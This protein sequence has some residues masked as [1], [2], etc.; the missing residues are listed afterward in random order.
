MDSHTW[1]CS[2]AHN[3]G[4]VVS[5]GD[6][7]AVSGVLLLGKYTLHAPH[8][9]TRTLKTLLPLYM[10]TSIVLHNSCGLRIGSHTCTRTNIQLTSGLQ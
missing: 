10:H 5:D 2:S 3:C 9:H 1:M 7:M 8:V 4:C 6:A